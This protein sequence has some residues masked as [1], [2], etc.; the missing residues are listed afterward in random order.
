MDELTRLI[1]VTVPGTTRLDLYIKDAASVSRT[2]ARAMIDAGKVI[3][4]SEVQSKYHRTVRHGDDV[5]YVCKEK[6]GIEVVP[7]TIP[8]D[9]VHEGVSYIAVNKPAGMLTHPTR[10]GEQDTLVNAVKALYPS[11]T[12]HAINRLDRFT[13]GIVLVALDKITAEKLASLIVKRKVY[14]EYACLV[15]GKINKKGTI[16]LALSEGGGGAKS[17]EVVEEGG[18]RAF[19]E[20]EPIEVFDTA[21]LLRII[22][23]T[24]RTHQIRAHMKFIKHPVI[25]DPVYGDKGLDDSLFTSGNAPTRQMLHAAVMEFILSPGEKKTIIKAR[26]PADI[27]AA[28]DIVRRK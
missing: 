14:K 11:N 13:S 10:F 25:G 6:P 20:Y 28:L 5:S 4:N 2:I 27:N 23:K 24:G 22:I 3:V 18:M 19:T 17:R 7:H 16:D 8:L 26:Y 9:I 1:K 15:H 21:T 12:I